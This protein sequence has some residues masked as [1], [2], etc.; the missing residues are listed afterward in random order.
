MSTEIGTS[1]EEAIAGTD[2]R[3]LLEVKDLAVHFS[4]GRKQPP[5]KAVDGIS[6]RLAAGRA[7]AIVGESGS[8]K[9][10]GVRALLGLLADNGRIAGGSARFGDVDLLRMGQR[11]LQHVRGKDIAMVFQDAMQSLNPTLTLE[12]QLVEHQ[13][14]HHLCDRNTARQRAIEALDS[15]G[16]PE[17]DRRI[18]SYPFELSG[19]LR[20]RAMIAMAMV[21][22]PKLL[23]ADEPTTAV[24]V[25]LQRQILDL[26]GKF[27]DQGTGIIMITHDLGV[28]RDLCEEVAV[29]YAGRIV[30]TGP[31]KQ[32]LADPQHPYTRGLVNSTVEVGD[33]DRPLSPI[34]GTPP[35]LRSIPD[36]CS[37]RPRCAH[38]ESGCRTDQVLVPLTTRSTAEGARAVACWK[39]AEGALGVDE[40]LVVDESLGVEGAVDVESA[41][42]VG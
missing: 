10:V 31:M 30:E 26:L 41:G 25:T 9:S 18:K 40:S 28:A 6:Y 33:I 12:R 16:V 4:A 27:K 13:L 24:D 3:P 20:Q 1:K 19:G 36:G 35:S 42:G 21:T 11:S 14:W 15:V 17:P 29:M 22:G 37:F 2:D 32:V 39:A 34:P 38:A 23:I 8:G 7:L 5:L